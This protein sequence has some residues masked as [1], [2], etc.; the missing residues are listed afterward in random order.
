[1]YLYSQFEVPDSRRVFAVFEQPDLKAT[2][3]FPVTA[4]AEWAVVS[5]SVT[6]TPQPSSRGRRDLALRADAAHL[7]LHHGAR[8]RPVPVGAL[9]AHELER[10]RHPARRLRAQVALRSYL[11]AD[12]IFEKTRQGFAYYEEKFG[13]PYPFAKYDQLFV[14]EFNAGAMENAGAVT[15]TET[16]VFRS[17]GD[18][19]DQGAPRRHDPARARPHVV[20]RPRHH[21]VVE[22]PV[23]QRVVRRVGVDDRDRRGHRVER[24]LDDLPGDGEELGLPARTS[25]RRR[26]RSSR[27]ST[28]S[29]TC[30]STS[31]A[32]PTPRAARCSSSSPPGSASRRSSPESARTSSKHEYG[33]T[34]LTDLLAELETDERP[35]A[36]RLGRAVARDRRRQH[37]AP[38][39]E[40]DD[41]GVIT[42]FRDRCR[43]RRPTTRRSARTASRVGFYDFASNAADAKLVRVHRVELDVDGDRHRGAGAGRA[44][45]ARPR[46][47]QRR[48]PRLREDPPRRRARSRSR[49][50]TSRDIERP[51]RAR[52]RLG[53]G[54]GL[55]A[56]R[57]GSPVATTSTSCSATSRA[58]PRSTTMRSTL[59]QLA[60]VAAHLRGA[61]DARRDDPRGSATRSGSSRRRPRPARTRSSSSS[62]SSRTSRRRPSTSP[63][64]SA[65]ARRHDDARRPRDRHRPRLGAARGPRAASAPPASRDRRGPREGQHRER[66]AGRRAG[67]R[68]DPDPRRQARRARRRSS[69]IRRSPN[70]IAAQHGVS[71]SSTST[72]PS[73]SRRWPRPTSRRSPGSGRTAATRSRST[74]SWASTRRRSPREPRAARRDARLARREPGRARRCA[75]S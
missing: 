50:R 65:P 35:R 71:A 44:A 10:P 17:Q 66:P 45:A 68:H 74:S 16:Y 47:A 9:R 58:R 48:R 51:A 27:P 73:R 14:P 36:V 55:D 61:G 15:F 64:L 23:A 12:Y 26:T 52:A 1:M 56:R 57:R 11:D 31:T 32:S 49:S 63:S 6:P 28:T 33:N 59:T 2:F 72:T 21:E 30:R 34:E 22:R 69:T 29:K 62:S 39:I 24:G 75:A 7:E 42:A 70:A 54:L 18:R 37:A 3:R 38:E 40:T 19:R 4:P 5:N 13:Y 20:R 60:Q 8:R 53:R 25:C 67:P 46:A 41:A 43:R